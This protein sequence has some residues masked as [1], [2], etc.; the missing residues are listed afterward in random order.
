MTGR[1][2]V[3]VGV[4]RRAG[5][6]NDDGECDCPACRAKRGG[7]PPGMPPGLERMMDEMGPEALLRALEEIMID[8]G[9]GGPPRRRRGRSRRTLPDDLLF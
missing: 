6:L 9:M 3:G 4:G 5:R 7:M 2:A 1:K 8:G